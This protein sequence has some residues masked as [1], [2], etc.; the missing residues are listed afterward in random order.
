[1]TGTAYIGVL[2]LINHLVIKPLG[3][4]VEGVLRIS[5]AP[6]VTILPL[7]IY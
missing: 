4:V 1:M 6:S 5:V 3:G 2:S 7:S